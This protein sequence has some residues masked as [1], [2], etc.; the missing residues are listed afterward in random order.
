MWVLVH[1]SM[2]VWVCVCGGVCVSWAVLFQVRC[3]YVS[4]NLFKTCHSTYALITE[5]FLRNKAQ[6]D[7]LISFSWPCISNQAA[8]TFYPPPQGLITKP[9]DSSVQN[10]SSRLKSSIYTT[11]H[12]VRYFFVSVPLQCLFMG[13]QTSRAHGLQKGSLWALT[14]SGERAYEASHY[15]LMACHYF[16]SEL[17]IKQIVNTDH[18]QGEVV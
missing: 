6:D 12:I 3:K 10:Y 16:K 7:H 13:T 1:F 11:Q 18:F 9:T 4:D 8:L 17:N 5:G 14:K 15:S 2:I